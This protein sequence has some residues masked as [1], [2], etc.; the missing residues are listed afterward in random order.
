MTSRDDHEDFADWGRPAAA[1]SD[2]QVGELGPG[3]Q[4]GGYRIEAMAGGGGMGTVY[5]ATQL[6]LGRTVALKVIAAQFAADPGFRE[7]F[8]RESRLA[9]SLDHPN[10][11]T[12]HEAGEDAGRPFVSM[13]FV[14]GPNLRQLLDSEGALSPAR[15]VALVAHVA[16]AL[17]AAHAAGLVHRDVKPS[18]ILIERRAGTEFVYLT[19]FGLVKRIGD[20]PEL[21]GSAGWVGSVDYA[22]PEQVRGDAVDARTDIYALG[23]VLYTALSGQVPHPRSDLPAKLYASVNQ[24]TPALHPTLPHVPPGL[25]AVIARATAKDPRDRYAS[26][27]E[28]AGAAAAT[29]APTTPYPAWSPP[30]S[31]AE[32]R[33]LPPD[34]APDHRR[35]RRRAVLAAVA[36]FAV[37]AGGTGLVAALSGGGGHHAPSVAAVSATPT[38]SVPPGPTHT[39]SF[40]LA[41]SSTGPVNAEVPSQPL[42]SVPSS[43]EGV[44]LQLYLAKRQ[45]PGAVAVVFALQI[46]TTGQGISRVSSIQHSLSANTS[47]SNQTVSNVA[48]LD[49]AGLKEYQT[50][51]AD[52]RQDATC[53]CTALPFGDGFNS[54][55]EVFYYAALVA[56]PPSDVTSVSVVTGMGTF[57]NVKLSS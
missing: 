27:G 35:G 21:T 1:P 32:D 11:V 38:H 46:N 44:T 39:M 48:L 40:Q 22:A 55:G 36:A 43:V 26:A 4:I 54:T 31:P 3:T 42:S 5:R 33:P 23:A 25:D 6:G 41:D 8:R 14:E 12:V 45:T 28:L 2:D 50:F 37:V 29:A 24:P 15:A 20:D 53:L 47:N 10:V 9:A 30:T 34:P 56:A 18:N 16:A 17:D 57:V 49:A 51:M 19:D 13:R 7:R 52:P